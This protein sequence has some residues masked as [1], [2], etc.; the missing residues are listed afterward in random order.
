MSL[1]YLEFNIFFKY[2]QYFFRFFFSFFGKFWVQK[3][4]QL[5]VL[6]INIFMLQKRLNLKLFKMYFKCTI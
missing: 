2:F 1:T 6:I 5:F 4:S 3:T